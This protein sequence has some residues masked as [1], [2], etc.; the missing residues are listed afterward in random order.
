MNTNGEAV[1]LSVFQGLNLV[2]FFRLKNHEQLNSNFKLQIYTVNPKVVSN[3]KKS[4]TDLPKNDNVDAWVIAD[5]IRF[6]RVENSSS[7]EALYRALRQI[8]RHKFKLAQH[9][10]AE[11]ARALNLVFLKFSDLTQ[12]SPFGTFT[13]AS[14]ALLENYTLRE[15]VNT[16]VLELA[17]FLYQNSNNRL[18]GSTPIEK[19]ITALKKAARNSYRL[20][21]E[22]DQAI[23]QTL[24]MT[25][26]N[27]RFYQSQS[28]RLKRVLKRQL[29]AIPQTLITVDG[30]GPVLT[31]GII[32][33]ANSLRVHNDSY[34]SYYY[35]K[36]NEVPKHKHKRALVLTARKFVR[37]VFA[38]LSKGEIYQPRR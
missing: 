33:A 20:K 1:E 8:T 12:K 13:K 11:K 16:D 23:T 37:L 21:P 19:I 28:K 2:I 5:R 32:E 30:I 7:P 9:I 10:K 29:K 24:S 18:G 6:G 31:A 22:I 25:F 17:E 3:F 4:Y 36:Y 27:I 14:M 34:K 35:K 38:L 26:D 15:I